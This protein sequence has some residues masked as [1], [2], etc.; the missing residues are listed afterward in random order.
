MGHSQVEKAHSREKIL[1]EAARQIREDGLESISVGKL[2]KRVNLTHGGFYGHFASRS[3]LLA[4]ALERALV[5]GEAH[6]RAAAGA[7]RARSFPT[8]VRSYL[9]RTH[10]DARKTGCAI[11]ALASDTSRADPDARSVM[12]PHIEAFIASVASANGSPENDVEAMVAV[13]TMVGALLLSRVLTDTKRSDALLRTVRDHLI[14]RHASAC[15]P[16]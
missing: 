12:T 8:I 4:L 3:E 14:D 2:M 16:G 1:A 9:S 7:V 13:S 10:R 6:V 5:D 15:E 11:A